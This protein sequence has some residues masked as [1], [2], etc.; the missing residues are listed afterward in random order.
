MKRATLR[1]MAIA[2]EDVRLHSSGP[3]VARAVSE[4]VLLALGARA[5]LDVSRLDELA[6]ALGIAIAVGGARSGDDGSAA[7]RRERERHRVAGCARSPRRQADAAR[8]TRRVGRRGRRRDR[9]QPRCLSRPTRSPPGR[10][11][12]THAARDCARETGC[13]RWSA[14]WPGGSRAGLPREDLEQ[15]GVVGLLSAVPGLRP[16]A[17]HRRFRPTRRRSS[18]ARCWP[19]FAGRRRCTCRAPARDLAASVEAAADA[20]AAAQ[21]RPPSL[22]E[23]AAA[24]DLDEED[25]VTGLAAR[26]AL[27]PPAPD[28]VVEDAAGTE[29]AIAALEA[30]LHVGD[31]LGALDRRSQ[32]ILVMRFGLELSQAEI[33]E[34]LGISQ[35]HVSRLLRTALEDLDRLMG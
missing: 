32:A 34:R 18:S 29:D 25:V 10:R 6:L 21:G 16:G 14:A 15:A 33:G 19:C 20:V 8:G 22:S 9:A 17:R 24:A 28:D 26:R 30:R 11:A 2:P 3:D 13:C 12:A 35:M 4:P 27:A 23:I 7:R 5:G 1:A 31:L